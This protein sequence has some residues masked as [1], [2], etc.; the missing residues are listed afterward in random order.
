MIF[1]INDS[2]EAVEDKY[3]ENKLENKSTDATFKLPKMNM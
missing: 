1:E 3:K 2:L